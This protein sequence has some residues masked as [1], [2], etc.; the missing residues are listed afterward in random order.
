MASLEKDEL[1]VRLNESNKKN[2]FV[3]GN[4]NR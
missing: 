4:N 2:E 3:G 1:M